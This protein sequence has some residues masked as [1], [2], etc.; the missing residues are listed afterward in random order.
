[1][2]GIIPAYL[3]LAAQGKGKPSVTSFTDH[4]RVSG[5]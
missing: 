5:K 1:M 4:A 3:A 2:D